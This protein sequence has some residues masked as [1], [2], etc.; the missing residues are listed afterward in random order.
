M[1]PRG[2][3]LAANDYILEVEEEAVEDALI[4]RKGKGSLEIKD[5]PIAT[6]P[7]SPRTITDS[8]S[9]DKEKLQ[10]LTA[11]KLSSS[12]SKP[13]TISCSKHIKGAITRM[14]MRYD[15]IFR[16]IKKSFM[17]RKDMDTIAKT[18]EASLKVVVHKMVNETTYQ[19]MR[20]YISMAVSEG[21]KLEREKTKV[22]IALMFVDVNSAKR[23]RTSDQ[24]TYTR[25]KSSSSHAMEGSYLSGSSTQEQPQ[26]FDAWYDDQGTYDD[27]V[28][29][30]EVSPELLAVMSRNGMNWIP[31]T[32][33]QN[34]MQ[35]ALNDMMRT[36]CDSE[37]ENQYHLD[38]IKSYMLKKRDNP[39]EVYSNQRIVDVISVQYDQRHSQEFMKE[40]VVKGV[41][42]E[43]S[44]FSESDYKYL[45]K[46]DIE[47]IKKEKRIM[48]IDEIPKFCDATLKRVL[49]NVKKIN[50]DVKHGYADPTLSK[51]DAKFMMF[52]KK[53]IQER[54]RQ[55]DQMRRWES[56]MNRRPLQQRWECLE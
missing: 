22:D 28:P 23:Q 46:N 48:D 3:G 11:S 24:S 30:K 13:K 40:I 47:D 43:Y 17:P 6:T 8:L 52:S 34:R 29:Y 21:I 2:G 55:Q 53:Y 45:Y 20:D 5:T 18:I 25:G 37:E 9:S 39:D 16:H 31:T 36:R 35:D 1:L 56:Y 41:D 33:D 15:Y 26:D 12:S 42:G 10:E 4:K 27:E 50:L 54:L 44:H 49:K 7:I 14:S 38:K 32:G 51:D 19:N